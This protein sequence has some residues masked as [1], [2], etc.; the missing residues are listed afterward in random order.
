MTSR[1]RN[2]AITLAAVVGT[3]AVGFVAYSFVLSPFL[4]K[5]RQIA[6]RQKEVNDLQM[7]V[8]EILLQKRK[9]EAVRLQSLPADVG[10]AR[11]QYGNLLEKMFRRSD[12]SEGLK[13]TVKDPDVKS[14]P[15]LAPKKPAYTRLTWVVTAKGEVYHLVEFL[16]LFYQQP[17]LHSIKSMN[18]QRPSAASA[19]EKRELDIDLTVEALVLDGAPDRG[20]ILP[21]VR[22]LA[23][24]SGPAAQLGFNQLVASGRG[25]PVPPT[26]L[27][28][29]AIREYLAIAGKDVFFGP[30]RE[31]K[32]DTREDD[33]SRFVVLTSVVGYED[34]SIVA[35]VRDQSTNNEYT[36]TQKP[37]GKLVV[38]TTYEVN[39]RKRQLRK[40]GQEI[41]YG[42]VEGQNQRAWRVRRV[43]LSQLILERLDEPGWV[44]K[45]PAGLAFAGGGPGQVLAVPEGRVVSLSAHQTLAAPSPLLSREAWRAIYAPAGL[46]PATVSTDDRGR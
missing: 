34:G 23:L 21:V 29:V 24:L 26:G 45:K 28:A 33:V 22:E 46:R 5:G 19:R 13:I 40:P 9:F 8:E 15:M 17:L 7:D 37:D 32:D 10:V 31:K 2:L 14:V 42:T 27:L 44:E 36:I 12:M 39:G 18:I 3:L 4:E 6:A 16:R 1:E 38:E 41:V 20:T 25:S 35:A 43:T 11:E 30:K